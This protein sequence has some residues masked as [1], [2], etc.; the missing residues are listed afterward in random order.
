MAEM[1]LQ[2][3]TL[4]EPLFRLIHTESVEVHIANDEIRL[5]PIAQNREGK[6][7]LPILGM[8]SDGK[9]TVENHHRRNRENKELER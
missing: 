5:I 8:Y 3:N 7:I 6:S 9:L 1:V 4:P 2:T